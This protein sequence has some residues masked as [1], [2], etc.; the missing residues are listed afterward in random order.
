MNS[1]VNEGEG[2]DGRV[3]GAGRANGALCC[4]LVF[5]VAATKCVLRPVGTWELYRHFYDFLGLRCVAVTM[6]AG[7]G[8]KTSDCIPV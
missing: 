2:R 6:K 1:E 4:A 8:I 5:H 3:D 7:N